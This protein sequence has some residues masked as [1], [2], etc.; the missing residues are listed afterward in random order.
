MNNE[1]DPGF[2]RKPEQENQA[3]SSAGVWMAIGFW[4]LLLGFGAL[5]AQKYLQKQSAAKPPLI[6]SSQSGTGPA[7]A[8]N[9]TRRGHYRVEGLV[10]GHPVNFLVDTGATEVSIPESVAKRI[11]LRRGKAGYATTANGTA[12]I[13]STEIQ[14][15]NIGPLQRMNVA[16]HISPGLAESDALLGMSFLRHYDLVQRGNQLQIQTP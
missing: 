2:N 13:Y 12:V 9:G 11:G 8:L 5:G 10:N 7:I 4:V 16:A 14:T 1:S 3:G 6:L 15:L